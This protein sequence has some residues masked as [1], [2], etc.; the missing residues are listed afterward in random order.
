MAVTTG[1]IAG[2]SAIF[3]IIA[4]CQPSRYFMIFSSIYFMI[5]TIL[6]PA[7]QLEVFKCVTN[8]LREVIIAGSIFIGLFLVVTVISFM[9]VLKIYH[10]MTR[11]LIR[12]FAMMDSP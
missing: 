6:L 1:I 12:T 4:T 8:D 2:G 9:F 7:A 3:I 5:I 10:K 11:K